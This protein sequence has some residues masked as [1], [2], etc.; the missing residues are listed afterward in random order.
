MV[1]AWEI[2][3]EIVS[4]KRLKGLEGFG[5]FPCFSIKFLWV[6]SCNHPRNIVPPCSIGFHGQPRSKLIPHRAS[7]CEDGPW[8]VEGLK[9]VEMIPLV[10]TLE[11]AKDVNE[12]LASRRTSWFQG[13]KDGQMPRG[14]QE[15]TILRI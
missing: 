10:R 9:N 14:S 1:K 15:T 13:L 6:I 12:V 5:V 11:M 8:S 3:K 4:S 7:G 2:R